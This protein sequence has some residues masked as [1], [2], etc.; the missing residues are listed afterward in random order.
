MSH[1]NEP[2]IVFIKIFTKTLTWTVDCLY[3]RSAQRIRAH[4]WNRWAVWL[5][6]GNK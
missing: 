2:K 4:L 1:S 3:W 5:S 6:G